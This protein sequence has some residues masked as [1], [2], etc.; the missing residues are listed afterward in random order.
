MIA[1]YVMNNLKDNNVRDFFTICTSVVLILLTIIA[2]TDWFRL[3]KTSNIYANEFQSN[4]KKVLVENLLTILSSHSLDGDTNRIEKI[5]KPFTETDLIYYVEVYSKENKLISRSVNKN[6]PIDTGIPISIEK[7]TLDTSSNKLDRVE[8]ATTDFKSKLIRKSMMI[9]VGIQNTMFILAIVIILTFTLKKY[10]LFSKLNYWKSQARRV[11]FRNKIL[12]NFASELSQPLNVIYPILQILTLHP[13]NIDQ[14]TYGNLRICAAA[15]LQL[16]NTLDQAYEYD[17]S[18]T[19]TQPV[20]KTTLYVNNL[21]ESICLANQPNSD[22]VYLKKMDQKEDLYLEIDEFRLKSV[23]SNLMSNA[24]KFTKHGKIDID[25]NLVINDNGNK[26]LVIRIKD[27]GCGI[28]KCNIQN[29]FTPFF[30]ENENSPGLGIGLPITKS[31]LNDLDGQLQIQS[32]PNQGTTIEVTIPNITEIKP[33]PNLP[34]TTSYKGVKALIID[35]FRSNS[36]LLEKT[37]RSYQVDC[38]IY[39]DPYEAIEEVYEGDYQ[40]IFINDW[41][42]PMSGLEFSRKIANLAVHIVYLTHNPEPD[43][44]SRLGEEPHINQYLLKPLTNDSIEK[45]LKSTSQSKNIVDKVIFNA[46]QSEINH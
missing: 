27:T 2:I 1:W 37:L 22:F 38:S 31:F 10:S 36:A 34:G 21:I 4:T 16:K 30:K 7:I 18:I 5:I 8:I 24:V 44:I 35:A 39:T 28:Q 40:V 26:S 43:L 19:N 15:S 12:R 23:I 42:P 14:K 3:A 33:V 11:D 41:I 25:W 46:S 17:R 20:Q 29:V 32:Y 6:L 45:I 13:K 9:N